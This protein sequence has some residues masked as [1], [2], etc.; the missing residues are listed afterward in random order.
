MEQL[1]LLSWQAPPELMQ[2]AIP[3]GE[4]C[5]LY[6]GFQPFQPGRPSQDL[7]KHAIS[8]YQA[9]VDFYTRL[10]V[11]FA[12]L[13]VKNPSVTRYRHE[14]KLLAQKREQAQQKIRGLGG[15]QNVR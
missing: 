15:E 11:R 12:D 3:T 1:D 9:Q 4:A 8:W 6:P 13:A 14:I 7:N 5:S 10:M 2:P